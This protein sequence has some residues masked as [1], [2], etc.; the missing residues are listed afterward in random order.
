MNLLS[1]DSARIHPD[2]SRVPGAD[3]GDHEPLTDLLTVY[4][5]FGVFTANA[6]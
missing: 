6:A 1:Q 4:T 3:G 5:G 2:G